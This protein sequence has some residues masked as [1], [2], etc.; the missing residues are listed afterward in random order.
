MLTHGLP[1]CGDRYGQANAEAKSGDSP[2]YH[3]P[4]LSSVLFSVSILE[5]NVSCVG[6]EGAVSTKILRRKSIKERS[7]S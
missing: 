5:D 3:I 1:C 4:L 2:N 7:K 6:E